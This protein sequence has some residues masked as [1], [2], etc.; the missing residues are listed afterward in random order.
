VIADSGNGAHL[1]YRVD[2]ENDDHSR[3]LVRKSLEV[4]AI[5]FSIILH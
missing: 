5:L 2:L 1:L 4:L 3:D